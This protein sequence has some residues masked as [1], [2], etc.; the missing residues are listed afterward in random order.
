MKPE[1][2]K[3][4]VKA[5][6]FEKLF[7]FLLRGDRGILDPARLKESAI[8]K[9]G[10]SDFGDPYFEK[11]LDCIADA[12]NNDP[13][14]NNLGR[15]LIKSALIH[16]LSNRLLLCN[17]QKINKNTG[18]IDL[19]PPIII[20]G[21]P[22][23]GTTLLHRLLIQDEKNYGTPLWEML[24]PLNEPGKKDRRS[25]KARLEMRA[26]NFIKGNINHIHYASYKEPEECVYLLGNTFNALLYWI[27][28]PLYHYID[29]F[30]KQDRD[31]KYKDYSNYL[32]LIQVYHPGQRLVM[33]S[34]EHLGSI[35]EIKNNIPGVILVETH[36]NPVECLNSMNSLLYNIH[37]SI[38]QYSDKNQLAGS[39]MKLLENELGRNRQARKDQTMKVIDVWYEDLI[40]DPIRVVESIYRQ[41][42]LP[43]DATFHERMQ[44]YIVKNPKN[45]FGEHKY[46]SQ[47]FGLID[48]E[49]KE[50][51]S[52]FEIPYQTN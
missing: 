35:A 8:K 2:H 9:V 51:F 18:K 20:T 33:K 13:G 42:G 21:L 32:K 24:R 52:P 4:S 34:P 19:I 50:K 47:S 44:K 26:S 25:L 14:L 5:S 22:R 28:F 1:H 40:T 17:E 36:R 43:L 15:F 27:Q 39:N 11:G 12:V 23:S 49:I 31:N 6:I 29:W 41:A 45:K 38:T 37:R 7:G 48:D 10:F 3:L 30:I 46:D 16:N